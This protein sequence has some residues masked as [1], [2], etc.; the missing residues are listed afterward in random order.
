MT[1]TPAPAPA[2]PSRTTLYVV[3]AIVA[4]VGLCGVGLLV[5]IAAPNFVNYRARSNQSEAIYTLK[6]VLTAEEAFRAKEGTWATQPRQLVEF[7]NSGPQ[8]FTCF[9]SPA[10][11]WGGRPQLKFEQL[12]PE[13][14][15]RLAENDTAVE[16]QKKQPPDGGGPGVDLVIVCAINLDADPALDIW[17]MTE[18]DPTPRHD[19][20]DRAP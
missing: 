10:G 8:K 4:L 9:L 1:P 12:P 3:L 2:A 7:A 19:F 16:E 13:V 20:D 5:A 11:P 17:S 18:S 14:Q 6:L 15:A